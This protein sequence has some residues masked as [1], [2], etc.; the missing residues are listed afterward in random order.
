MKCQHPRAAGKDLAVLVEICACACN[1]YTNPRTLANEKLFIHFRKPA[2]Y[3]PNKALARYSNAPRAR[4]PAHDDGKPGGLV[5][6]NLVE[7]SSGEAS[8][9]A[10]L[11]HGQI[12]WEAGGQ[13][14]HFMSSPIR[15]PLPIWISTPLVAYHAWPSIPSPFGQIAGMKLAR[16]ALA[17]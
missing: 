8:H 4:N 10:G 16:Q 14:A 9:L 2:L 13:C 5:V 3:P 6:Q 17:I 11:V 1:Q 7:G 12:L 15:L